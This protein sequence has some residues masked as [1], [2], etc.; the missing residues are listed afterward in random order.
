[1]LSVSDLVTYV[2]MVSVVV[3]PC[4]LAAVDVQTGEVTPRKLKNTHTQLQLPASPQS[5]QCTYYT[6]HSAH[7]TLM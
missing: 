6:L 7:Y 4:V 2:G 3:R 5:V 1:M